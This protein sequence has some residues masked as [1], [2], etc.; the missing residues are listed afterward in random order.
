MQDIEIDAE[1]KKELKDAIEKANVVLTKIET[2]KQELKDIILVAHEETDIPKKIIAKAAK[3]YFKANFK[4][5]VSENEQFENLFQT[6]FE[7]K[8]P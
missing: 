5:L 8:N 6:L 7:I 1:A 3:T 2:L 4:E